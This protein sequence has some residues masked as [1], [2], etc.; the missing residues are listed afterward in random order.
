MDKNQCDSKKIYRWKNRNLMHKPNHKQAVLFTIISYVGIAIG[1]VSTLFIYPKN[2]ELLGVFRYVEALAQT[3]FPVLLL[4]GSQALIN[5]SPKLADDLKKKL[6]NFNVF[7]ILS[8]SIVGILI[9]G[10][11]YFVP[12]FS[13]MKYVYFS[14]AMAICLAF[15]E[16]FKKQA[17]IIQKIAVPTFFDNI[18]PK[19][20]LPIVFLMLLYGHISQQESLLLYV[21]ASLLVLLLS[22]FYLNRKWQSNFDFNF[23]TLFDNIKK[24]DYYKFSFFAFAGSLGSVFAFRLDALLIPKLINMEAL[25]TFSIGVTLAS[26]LAIPATGIF[27][28]YAPIVSNHLKNNDILNLGKDYKAVAKFLFFIGAL[29]YSCIFLGIENLFSL[30]PSAEN[31]LPSVPIILILGLNVIFNIGT[32]FNGEIITYSKFYKFNLFAILF[33]A[34]LNV[35]LILTFV[36]FFQFGIIGVAIASFISMV[37]FNL[38]KL[39]FIYK[40]F[41]LWP[42][43]LSY[44]KLVLVFS[45]VLC[46][47]YFLPN[48]ASIFWNLI[49]KCSL[50]LLLNLFIIYKLKLVYQYNLK[51][52]IIIDKVK[53][54]I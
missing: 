18:I 47:V 10:I 52:D 1:I 16:L 46:G 36:K 29:I 15:I 21:G 11:L 8:K 26:A 28:L 38:V 54:L 4:G 27:V 35:V 32:G 23:S 13:G 25:G 39:I 14:F 40:K 7:S 5:F 6:F 24:R 12:V 37:L 42:F 44:L 43:D 31:L 19:L 51:A 48:S 17:T 3:I 20:A 2:K 34:L 45:L 50:C 33:L 9:L 30:L 22:A 49:H 41:G 53:N